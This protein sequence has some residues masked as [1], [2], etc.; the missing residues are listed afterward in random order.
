[1]TAD[2][3]RR[4]GASEREIERA[5]CEH[6]YGTMCE[7]SPFG[8]CVRRCQKCGQMIGIPGGCTPH[9]RPT[10]ATPDKSTGT[11]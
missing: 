10:A 7:S 9:P 5:F 8:G 6:D 2:D 4:L 11:P 3:L 1:V